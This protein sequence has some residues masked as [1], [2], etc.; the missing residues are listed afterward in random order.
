MFC[1]IPKLLRCCFCLP[2][3][4]GVLIF[5]YINIIFSAFMIG[6]YSYSVHHDIGFT[7]M[8]HGSTSEVE[9]AVCVGIYCVEIV[10]NVLL[11]Y[12]AHVR[13]LLFL[14]T[15]YYY[16]IATALMTFIVEIISLTSTNHIGLV[17]EMLALYVAGLCLHIYL[18]IVVRSLLI[19]LEISDSHAYENQLQQIVSGELKVESNG[20][21]PST[22]VPN[23]DA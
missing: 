23:N 8:Y 15:F 16:A 2:L 5:G 11:V 12:G 1:E 3:R 7:M 10:M 4:K 20:V 14:K 13:N 18:I 17:I 9:D 21:Y 22:V 19:K 6:M